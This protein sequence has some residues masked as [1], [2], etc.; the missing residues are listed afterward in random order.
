[1]NVVRGTLPEPGPAQEQLLIESRSQL[2]LG[3]LDR[4]HRVELVAAL[5]FLAVATAVG[6]LADRTRELDGLLAIGLVGMYALA[7]RI[8]IRIAS[9]WTD[10]S[11]LVF[12]PMLLLLPTGIVPLL[13]A[14][15]LVLSRVTDYVRG[16]VHAD[17][18]VLRIADAW[19]SIWP[20]LVL[21]AFGATSPDW[22]DWPVYLLALVAQIGCDG[23]TT[24]VR[25]TYGLGVRL[26]TLLREL[27]AIYAVDALLAPAGLLVALAAADQPGGSLL[28]VPLLAVFAILAREREARIESALVLS[29]AYRGT[30]LLLSNVLSSTDEYTGH[31]SRS[32][33]VLAHQ[34]ADAMRLDATTLRQV[35][36]G[37]LLHDVGKVGVPNEIIQKPGRLTEEEIEIMRQHT[38]HGEEM[39]AQ[40]GGVLEDAGLVVRSH[41]EHFDGG[42]YPDGL[43]GEEIPIAARIISAC[44]AFN[45]MTTDRPYRDAMPIADAI[46]ELR[47][48]AGGQF[49]PSVVETLIAIAQS[50][51]ADAPGREPLPAP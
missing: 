5:A 48:G 25:V 18:L 51:E 8:E 46:A 7:T 2:R 32:V 31:H 39:L 6:V 37:A 10:P 30:A 19:Y 11:Q 43:K 24:S 1:M 22:G 3:L 38:I 17:R 45:A 4:E 33:V 35:E 49:D 20:V 40:I 13:V 16:R 23:V 41:H 14:S 47:R 12:V 36:F 15:A 50:W 27:V 34:V 42:G 28:I 26:A 21:S 44:D 29:D 9:G